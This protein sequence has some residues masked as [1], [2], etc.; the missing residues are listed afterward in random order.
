MLNDE[1]RKRIE[2]EEQLRYH[3]R[4][5]LAFMDTLKKWILI[6]LI[7]IFILSLSLL[8]YTANQQFWFKKGIHISVMFEDNPQLKKWASV[9]Y[10][11]QRIGTVQ[12]IQAVIDGKGTVGIET[13]L[14]ILES[15]KGLIRIDSKVKTVTP[16]I[17]RAYIDIKPGSPLL[18]AVNEGET[19]LSQKGQ[20]GFSLPDLILKLTGK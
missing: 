16:L 7:S 11:G 9:K 12:E 20:N 13:R 3:T 5:R 1:E 2:E 19:L 6:I 10:L 14:F 15:E 17:G 8:F 4:K 18:P